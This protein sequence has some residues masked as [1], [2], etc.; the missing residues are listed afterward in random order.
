[1]ST[2]RFQTGP[3]SADNFASCTEQSEG[4]EV[5]RINM[6]LSARCSS[7]GFFNWHHWSCTTSKDHECQWR[8]TKYTGS[9]IFGKTTLHLW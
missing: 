6:N 9:S 1:M 8:K 4:T 7:L 2:G 3:S 5:A